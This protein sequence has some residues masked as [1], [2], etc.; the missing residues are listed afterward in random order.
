MALDH[1]VSQVYLR[2]W[3]DPN[4]GLLRAIRKADLK[5]FTPRPKDVCRIEAGNTNPYVQPERA[6]EEFL[7]Y[8][9]PRFSRAVTNLQREK[10]ER[11]TLV[12]IAGFIAYIMVCSPGGT[13]INAALLKE[14][15]EETTR[16]L[17]R[18]GRFP[19]PPKATGGASFT[20]L[21]EKGAV[22]IAIDEKFPQA[23]GVT[24]ILEFVKMFGNFGW[25][26]MVNRFDDSPFLTSDF[27]VAMEVTQRTVLNR[28]F[29]LAPQLAIRLHPD[30][31]LNSDDLD[32]SFSKFHFKV[33]KV[34]RP[35]VRYI[36]ELIV[37]CAENVV[38]CNRDLPWVST[39]VERNAAYRVKP[40]TSMIP[41]GKGTLMFNT[42]IVTDD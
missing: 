13:R 21:L 9:E 36:N 27:P 15:V 2:Q 8:I 28:I 39:F 19:P 29:P 41:H 7:A 32:F 23:F 20:E 38:F 33:R 42:T 34:S 30:P 12:V 18:Q 14:I 40:V 31:S 1:Y 35:Q 37:R 17:D 5:C 3:S 16:R 4:T 24:S 11:E 10:F 22:K 25:E 6:I 26:I